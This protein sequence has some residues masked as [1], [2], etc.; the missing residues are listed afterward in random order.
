MKI[1]MSAFD[2]NWE[3]KSE[4]INELNRNYERHHRDMRVMDNEGTIFDV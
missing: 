3:R 2:I 1:R 4:L